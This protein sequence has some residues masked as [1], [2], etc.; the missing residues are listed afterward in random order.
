MNV[1]FEEDGA[2]KAGTVLAD[3][4]TSLQVENQHGKRTKVKE[5]AV[6]IRFDHIPLSQF[7]ADAQKI[8]DDIDPAFLWECS[9][10]GEFGFGLHARRADDSA[11]G[12]LGHQVLEQR[13]LADPRLPADH[14]G[15]AQTASDVIEKLVELPA[16]G[17]PINQPINQHGPKLT[18]FDPRDQAA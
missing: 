5:A 2:F 10:E 12:R 11:P 9:G 4:N 18:R 16:L 6:L 8:S 15:L 14:E 3:N 1:F 13:R 7:M 17:E